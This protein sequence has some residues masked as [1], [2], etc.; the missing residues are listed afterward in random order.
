VRSVRRRDDDLDG[1][2]A[3]IDAEVPAWQVD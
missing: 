2:A 1:G 3:A